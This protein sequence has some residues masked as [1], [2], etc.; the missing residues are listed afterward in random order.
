MKRRRRPLSPPLLF[1]SFSL[2]L[3]PSLFLSLSLS[4]SSS[5]LL[6]LSPSPSLSLSDLEG[7]IRL[8]EG[9]AAEVDA[10]PVHA[11]LRERRHLQTA[12]ETTSG[13]MAPPKSGHPYLNEV[14]FSEK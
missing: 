14:A 3:T 1:L 5:L 6:S 12:L 2:A 4:L 10:G 7:L 9:H 13:Q 11:F 8:A